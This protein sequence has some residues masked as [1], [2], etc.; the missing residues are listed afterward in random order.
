[1]ACAGPR[2]ARRAALTN[3]GNIPAA[4]YF[5]ASAGRLTIT[6]SIFRHPRNGLFIASPRIG[7]T[8]RWSKMPSNH[9][10]RH[11]SERIGSNW[12]PSL[13][14]NRYRRVWRSPIYTWP[15]PLSSNRRTGNARTGRSGTHRAGLIFITRTASRRCSTGPFQ[16]RRRDSRIQSI[17]E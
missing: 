12:L 6:S 15:Y 4:S 3:F 13:I 14:S 8:W 16:F 9:G 7:R 11:A 17:T 10:S 1:M 5:Y 2:R